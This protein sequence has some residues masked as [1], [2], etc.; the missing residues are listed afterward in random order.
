[1]IKKYQYGLL[2]LGVLLA[3]R[4][5]AQ[6]PLSLS[7]AIA[8]GLEQ[9]YNIRLAKI[10]RDIAVNNDDWA[11]AG[12][13]PTINLTLG[14]DNRYTNTNN[15]ASIQTNSS[16]LNNG[17]TPGI[18]M[19]WVLF[20]GYRVRYTKARLEQLANL[21]AGQLQ[22][23]IETTIQSI[24]L[25]YYGAQV[26]EELLVVLQEV[27]ALSR[28]RIDYQ[29]IR[30]EYGQA[31]T[32]D[33]LQTQDAYLSDS[34]NYLIQLNTYNNSLRNLLVLMG[35]DFNAA[36]TYALTTELA[37]ELRQYLYAD[38]EARLLQSNRTLE[39][40]RINRELATIGTQI[41]EATLSP[42][43]NLRVGTTY[44]VGVSRGTQTFNFGGMPSEQEVSQVA[45]KTFNG[46]LN[47]GA[48]YTIFDGG[49]RHRRIETARLGE[50]QADLSY[51]STAQSL[52]VQL[53]N[54]LA[55]YNNQKDLLQLSQAREDNARRNLSIAD[56]R[57]KGGIINSFDYRSIQLSYINATQSRLN[58]QL[59]LQ[60]TETDL[61]RLTGG[62]IR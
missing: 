39:N 14:T 58:A 42:T 40:L 38:L 44:N 2:L 1:M 47:V 17:L 13:Y 22:V 9:N 48:T 7:E 57:F 54:T 52:T 31:S 33:L 46:F 6:E 28:D 20:D 11:L 62:L 50:I 26:Q 51:E 16:I 5:V 53:A 10:D 18:E 8:I 60:N 30:K 23:Q 41:Q 4:G 45:A 35:V 37:T 25:A 21:S 34:T 61:T 3:V 32:F 29:E 24:I 19:N 49:A 59:N 55:T 56:E 27:M 15:P 43:V 36:P 12:R